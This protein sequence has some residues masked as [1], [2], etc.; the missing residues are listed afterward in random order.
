MSTPHDMEYHWLYMT[1]Q[2]KVRGV[3]YT[4]KLYGIEPSERDWG[5]PTTIGYLLRGTRR[6]KGWTV[7]NMYGNPVTTLPNELTADEARNAAQMILLS[8][9]EF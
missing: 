5:A 7:Q 3:T 2:P 8:L 1:F 9:K 6:N 4:L